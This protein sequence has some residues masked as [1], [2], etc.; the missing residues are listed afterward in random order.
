M[1]L[2]AP[3]SQHRVNEKILVSEYTSYRDAHFEMETYT[4]A[5]DS[6]TD[7]LSVVSDVSH[8]ADDSPF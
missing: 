6:D 7:W 5:M 2:G 8:D 4:S 1:V 3:D